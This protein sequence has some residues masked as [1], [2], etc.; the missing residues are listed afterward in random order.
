[1]KAIKYYAA[2]AQGAYSKKG[3]LFENG[4]FLCQFSY[5]H[6]PRY[7]CRRYNFSNPP[8]SLSWGKGVVN[9]QSES[10]RPGAVADYQVFLKGDVVELDF[11]AMKTSLKEQNAVFWP[12]D[13]HPSF[14]L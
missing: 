2:K 8:D 12:E 3:Y 6:A 14:S 11:E 5:Y 7:I 13:H 10:P 4:T 1:M 9:E